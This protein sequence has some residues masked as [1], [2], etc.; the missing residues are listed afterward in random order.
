MSA[1]RDDAEAR[2]ARY[3]KEVHDLTTQVSFLEEEVGMLRRKLAD[4]PRAVR[5]LEERLGEAQANVSNLVG[6]NER[7]VSTLREAREQIV[8][9]KEEIDRLAQPPSGY[10]VFLE[11]HEDGTVDIFTGGRK[12]RV[13]VSPTIEVAEL[14]RGQEVMLNEAMNVVLARA[15]CR[16]SRMSSR[17]GTGRW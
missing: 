17:T 4:S 13:S 9:L 11:A 6:Q 14:Q 8:A 16:C 15:R 7:L 12:L 10:G 3:E 5:V 2:A 1:Q